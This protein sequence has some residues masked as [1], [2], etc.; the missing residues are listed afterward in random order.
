MFTL[1]QSLRRPLRGIEHTVL[2]FVK[3]STA[4]RPLLLC[5]IVL[6]MADCVLSCSSANELVPEDHADRSQ[7]LALLRCDVSS[8]KKQK[9][10]GSKM[11][12]LDQQAADADANVAPA[13]AAF[14]VSTNYPVQPLI[15]AVFIL[16][17]AVLI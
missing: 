14:K 3:H 12:A 15:C 11:Q 4:L 6:H 9:A 17:T 1:A 5:G 2:T 16:R 10:A 13:V 8:A 7:M